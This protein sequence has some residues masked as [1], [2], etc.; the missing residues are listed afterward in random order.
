MGPFLT[1][2]TV[3][4]PFFFTKNSDSDISDF[5]GAEFKR[6]FRRFNRDFI[7]SALLA[8]F[9]SL[10]AFQKLTSATCGG[11]RISGTAN[12]IFDFAFFARTE[13]TLSLCDRLQTGAAD[14]E[15]GVRVKRRHKAR[16]FRVPEVLHRDHKDRGQF[17]LHHRFADA[18]VGDGA[19]DGRFGYQERLGPFFGREK[20]FDRFLRVKRDQALVRC[21]R[22]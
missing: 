17:R 20:L 7:H 6:D 14:A 12:W 13:G 19:V 18:D 2:V 4:V 21:P 8:V 22:F 16:R 11:G 5:V 10:T 9:V 1:T 3:A 15:R